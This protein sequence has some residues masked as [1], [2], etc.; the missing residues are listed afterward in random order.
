MILHTTVEGLLKQTILPD[1]IVLSLCDEGSVLRET[2]ALPGVHCVFGPPGS[3]IQRN[4]A[5]PLAR[6]PYVL[7]LDDDVELAPDYIEQMERIFGED[8]S[9]AASGGGVIADGARNGNEIEREAAIREIL[10][11]RGSR[12]CVGVAFADLCGF[13]M[14]VRNNV[15]RTE[16]F[17][18]RLPLYGWLEDRDFLHRC[19]KHGKIVRHQGAWIVHLATRS[20]RTSDVRLGY[21]KIANPWYMWRK[22]VITSLPELIVRYWMKTTLANIIRA[23]MPKQPQSPDYKKRLKGNL[24]AYR[25]LV[26]F[27]IDPQNI[28][29]IPDSTGMPGQAQRSEGAL[30]SA[31][32]RPA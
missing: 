8:K 23:I 14:F 9:I 13:N 21:T 31:P 22:S 17:D 3:S 16:R 30:R 7:F 6:T 4:T 12:A 26:L 18:E 28:L 5:I 15:L 11:Y 27:R 25:D 2:E 1:S 29:N 32:T 10:E 19:A 24:L 20:G